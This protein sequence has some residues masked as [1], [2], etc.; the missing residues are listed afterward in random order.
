MK[1]MFEKG[2]KGILAY[3]KDD[4]PAGSAGITMYAKASRKLTVKVAN[5]PAAVGTEWTKLDFPWEK[6]TVFLHPSQRAVRIVRLQRACRAGDG[7][8]TRVLSLGS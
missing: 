2:S 1:A 8:R 4:Y 3:E 7:N 6:W 5:V